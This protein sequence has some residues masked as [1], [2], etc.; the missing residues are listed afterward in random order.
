MT[1]LLE[2]II[3]S[4]RSDVACFHE[5]RVGQTQENKPEIRQTVLR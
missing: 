4:K 1:S 3:L 2:T 5:R